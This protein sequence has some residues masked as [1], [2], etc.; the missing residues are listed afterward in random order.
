MTSLPSPCGRARE[1]GSLNETLAE[2]AER[3]PPSRSWK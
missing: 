1:I 3:E 2:L